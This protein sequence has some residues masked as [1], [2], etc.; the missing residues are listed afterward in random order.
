MGDVE[1]DWILDAARRPPSD[2]PPSISV[3]GGTT[4]INVT[5]P[6]AATPR[7]IAEQIKSALALHDTE[8]ARKI[9]DKAAEGAPRNARASFSPRLTDLGY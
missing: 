3:Q 1:R 6:A 7:E 4:T 5:V 9:A 2:K 8:L